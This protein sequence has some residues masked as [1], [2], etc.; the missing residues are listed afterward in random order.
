MVAAEASILHLN[1]G[2]KFDK[3]VF[4]NVLLG[5]Y[6]GMTALGCSIASLS[7]VTLL[8]GSGTALFVVME[9]KIPL[10]ISEWCH[11]RAVLK[12]SEDH[13]LLLYR[14]LAG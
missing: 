7:L 10:V 2:E 1:K 11:T 12:C 13:C 9:S 4:T 14:F 8:N 3:L 6:L 5:C